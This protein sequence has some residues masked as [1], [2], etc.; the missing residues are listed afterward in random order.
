MDFGFLWVFGT[1]FVLQHCLQE[2]I[3]KFIYMWTEFGLGF[4]CMW[5][6]LGLFFILLWT[7]RDFG[8]FYCGLKW[9]LFYGF[10]A[11]ICFA[12]LYACRTGLEIYLYVD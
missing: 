6:R 7:K 9:T 10:W 8:F 5:T 2:Y 4:I 12:I 11:R 3:W 1:Q